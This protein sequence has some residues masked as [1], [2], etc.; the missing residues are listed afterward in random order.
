V[1]SFVIVSRRSTT[2]LGTVD[3]VSSER[4]HWDSVWTAKSFDEVSW[5][6]TDA[7]V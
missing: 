6:Q 4:E 5:H 7:Q 1:H 3:G 2:R